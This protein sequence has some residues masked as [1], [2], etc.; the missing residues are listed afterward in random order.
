MNLQEL[1]AAVR[2]Q[3]DLDEEDLP[4][5]LLDLYIAEGFDQTINLE[6]RWP[7]YETSWS[8]SADETG[9][10]VAPINLAGIASVIDDE[11]QFPLLWVSHQLA[12]ENFSSLGTGQPKYFSMWGGGIYL[13]PSPPAARTVTIR[14]WRLPTAWVAEGAAAEADADSRLHLPLIHYACSRAYAQQE[15]E[16]LTAVY[17][18]SWS[19]LVEAARRAIM[20]S[21][22]QGLFQLNYGFN[23]GRAQ[24]QRFVLSI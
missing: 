18:D 20:R 1:R 14:G 8:V 24:S 4:N 13:W 5:G 15:D 2:S 10:G 3:L 6:K 17:I 7:F 21:D 9:P 23:G 22:Y 16:V 19:R 11:T 12:E